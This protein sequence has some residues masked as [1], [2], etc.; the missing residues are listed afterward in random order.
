MGTT[1]YEFP[2][3]PIDLTEAI[4]NNHPLIITTAYKT[5]TRLPQEI[6]YGI[7]N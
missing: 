2:D 5:I 1:S 6:W 4:L 3:F 7:T